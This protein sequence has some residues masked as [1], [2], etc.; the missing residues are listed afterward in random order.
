VLFEYTL[1]SPYGNRGALRCAAAGGDQEEGAKGAQGNSCSHP[2]HPAH[3]DN[4]EHS[5]YGFRTTTNV[6]LLLP[7]TS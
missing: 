6:P 1:D 2:E 7:S 3:P 5:D 4:P